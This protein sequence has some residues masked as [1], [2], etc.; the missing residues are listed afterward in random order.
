MIKNLRIIILL[1]L[2]GF[3]SGINA[4][5]V[6]DTTL[7]QGLNLSSDS[8]YT[9]YKI[10][11]TTSLAFKKPRPFEHFSHSFTDVYDYSVITFS[12]DNLP[13]LGWV[14]ASTL[15]LLVYDQ[16][17]VDEA[18][19]FGR[20]IGV[21]STNRRKTIG[22]VF[23]FPIQVPTDLPSSLYFIGDGWT[24][25]TLTASILTYGLINDDA[26]ALRTAS[27]L[28]EG[29][30]AA[31]YV[32]QFLKHITGRQAPFK[33]TAPSGQWHFFPNQVKYHKNVPGYDAYPS[34]HL[35]VGLVTL[36]V[37]ADNYP[38]YKFIKPL[39]YSLLTI[40]AYQMLNNGVHWASDYPLSIVMG[41][42]I[43][44]LVTRRGRKTIHTNQDESSFLDRVELG[45]G[46]GKNYQIGLCLSYKLN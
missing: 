8:S 4:Q 39:G 21:G 24:H 37:I 27:Q 31:T 26:R 5:S 18:K 17:L 9:V 13:T 28:A 34:G 3:L 41:Y 19:R 6:T 12:K 10:D 22:N 2:S 43:T 46:A 32:T 38:E 44:E 42:T 7:P 25:V 29:I 16:A 1:F 45:I 11:P 30:L 23:G 36:L 15:L 40:L 35:A 14:A 33:S 20:R